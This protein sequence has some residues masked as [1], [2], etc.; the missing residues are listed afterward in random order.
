MGIVY[1]ETFTKLLRVGTKLIVRK[2]K[3]LGN[4]DMPAA[5]TAKH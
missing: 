5:C 4:V 3:R 1:T 2:G